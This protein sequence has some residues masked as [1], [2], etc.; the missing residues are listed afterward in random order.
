MKGKGQGMCFDG[1][2]RVRWLSMELTAKRNLNSDG[3]MIE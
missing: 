1:K 2:E 3:I